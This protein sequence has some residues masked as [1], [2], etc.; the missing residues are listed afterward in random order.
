MDSPEIDG[1][2]IDIVLTDITLHTNP[3]RNPDS[4]SHGIQKAI[5]SKKRGRTQLNRS[6]GPGTDGK[7]EIQIPLKGLQEVLDRAAREGKRVRFFIPKSGIP[8]L[9]GNDTLEKIA[10]LKKKGKL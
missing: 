3:A 2:T 9:A 1:R 4:F 8:I 10:S 6:I 5:R 7:M